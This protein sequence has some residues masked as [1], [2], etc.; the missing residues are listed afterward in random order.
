M[1]RISFQRDPCEGDAR[2]RESWEGIS[3]ITVSLNDGK[4]HLFSTCNQL[5]ECIL[6]YDCRFK[7][8]RR[9]RKQCKPV[10]YN[11]KTADTWNKKHWSS[12]YCAVFCRKTFDS[13]I[14]VDAEMSR[15]A[16]ALC[17]NQM[18]LVPYQDYAAVT[19][20]SMSFSGFV[21]WLHKAVTTLLLWCSSY[22]PAATI[23]RDLK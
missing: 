19:Q 7:M 16:T 11:N 3:G 23:Q 20:D 17:Q 15:Y 9:R 13:C 4:L 6:V 21:C 22:W 12:C 5:G 1:S 8:K 14:L 2:H 18:T 10:S